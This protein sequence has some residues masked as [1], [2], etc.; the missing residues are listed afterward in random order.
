MKI[1]SESVTVSVQASLV[2]LA[3]VRIRKG[4]RELGPP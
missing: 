2:L 4:A 3:R 1:I